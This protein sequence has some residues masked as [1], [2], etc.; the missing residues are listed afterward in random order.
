MQNIKFAYNN[1][2][3]SGT[4]TPLTEE[5][6]SFLGTN[7]RHDWKKKSWR[8][9]TVAA[10]QTLTLD[11]GVPVAAQCG[12]ICFNNFTAA[13]TVG[14]YG[15]ATSDFSSPTFSEVLSTI[16]GYIMGSFWT[17]PQTF[18]FWQVAATDTANGATYLEI[19]RIFLGSYITPTKNFNMP[20]SRRLVDPSELYFSVGG[21]KT[22][23]KRDKYKTYLITFE[24]ISKADRDMLWNLYN[25]VGCE[26]NFFVNFD[27]DGTFADETIYGSFVT[28]PLEVQHKFQ[29]NFFDMALEF[30]EVL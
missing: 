28:N 15:N 22:A 14:F 23:I 27:Y 7:T 12:I 13:A 10:K 9:T 11:Y 17:A 18:Q 20:Y 30:R 21:Q 29:D 4:L 24:D 1:L 8:S 25:S 19:G 3:D 2:W 26:K 16:N 6:P 5:S